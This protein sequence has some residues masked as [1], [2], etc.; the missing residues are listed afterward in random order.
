MSQEIITAILAIAVPPTASWTRAFVEWTA[1]GD[2][3]FLR[4]SSCHDVSAAKSARIGPELLGVIGC[5]VA[6][7]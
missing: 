3:L 7:Q 1:P 6:S 4:R 2:F 5:K